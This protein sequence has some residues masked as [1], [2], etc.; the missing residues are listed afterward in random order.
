MA[1]TNSIVDYALLEHCIRELNS[2][3][4]RMMAVLR[5][6]KVVLDN[7]P[8][9]QVEWFDAENNPENPAM[10]TRKVPFTR[11]LYIEQ[12]DFM[13]DPPKKY[14]RL[15]PGNEVRLKNA[16]IIKCGHAVKE[17]RKHHELHC[18]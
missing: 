2:S 18:V 8:E 10:G 7:Y 9:N 3:A 16:Y 13:E 14:F 5:P 12:D 15:Y 11:E 6:L 17:T 4:P 1:K